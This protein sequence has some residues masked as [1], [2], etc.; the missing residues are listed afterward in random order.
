[1]GGRG[2]SSAGGGVGRNM[3]VPYDSWGETISIRSVGDNAYIEDETRYVQVPEVIQTNKKMLLADID[4]WRNDDGTYGDENTS[5]AIAYDDGSVVFPSDFEPGHKKYKRSGI[6]GVAVSTGDYEEVWGGEWRRNR[7][8]GRWGLD[9]YT[10]TGH[11]DY[12]DTAGLK[13]TYVGMKATGR[14]KVRVK[15]TYERNPITGRTTTKREI[16]RRSTIK[17]I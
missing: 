3:E 16:I 2:S 10:T 9:P 17:N 13:N 7:E 12:P 5:F 8:T 14:Y 15:T 6:V 11:D 1:M 4:A